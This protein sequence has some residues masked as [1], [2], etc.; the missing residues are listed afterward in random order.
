MTATP[1]PNTIPVR[2]GQEDWGDVAP[3]LC[4]C[5]A[6]L[7][8]GWLDDHGNLLC[9]EC[10]E[11]HVDDVWWVETCLL[12]AVIEDDEQWLQE[13]GYLEVPS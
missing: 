4:T 6:R 12:E 3:E 13:N 9:Q 1:R 7:H 8:E 10:W 2:P 11:H 5:L